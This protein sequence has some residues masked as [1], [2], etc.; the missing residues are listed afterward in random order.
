MSRQAPERDPLEEARSRGGLGYRRRMSDSGAGAGGIENVRG[1][2][3]AGKVEAEAREAQCG[4][5]ADQQLVA[6][7]EWRKWS[8]VSPTSHFF[9]GSDVPGVGSTG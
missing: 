3:D 2:Y 5:Q 7:R 9:A 1:G 6:Q 4:F 8:W